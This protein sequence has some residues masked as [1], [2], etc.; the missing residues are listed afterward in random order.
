MGMVRKESRVYVWMSATQE[1]RGGTSGRNNTGPTRTGM[2]R[3]FLCGETA[4]IPEEKNR[5]RDEDRFPDV[6]AKRPHSFLF[7]TPL[8]QSISDD[9]IKCMQMNGRFGATEGTT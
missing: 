7:R 5:R 9:K 4:Y 2:Q 8:M 1:T 6:S 3:P